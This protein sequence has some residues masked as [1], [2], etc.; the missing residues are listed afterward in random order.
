MS[1]VITNMEYHKKI[2]EMAI[3]NGTRD[4]L[5]K[6]LRYLH[7]YGGMEDPGLYQ[8]ELGYDH[9]GY[10][11]TWLRRDKDGEYQVMMIGGLIFHMASKEWSVHT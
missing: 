7:G 4:A 9:A 11:V 8:V 6:Q 10:G 2:L 5:E 1:L 3:K